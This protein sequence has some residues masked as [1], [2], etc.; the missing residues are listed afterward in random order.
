M[1]DVF[2]AILTLQKEIKE[3][4][5]ELLERETARAQAAVATEI[6]RLARKE[7]GADDNSYLP[8][9]VRDLVKKL[10]DARQ[11]I[12]GLRHEADRAYWG[13]LDM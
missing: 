2:S 10:A 8:D 9:V 7:A 13:V 12:E 4:K 11:D 3:L 1:A 5:I 6:I